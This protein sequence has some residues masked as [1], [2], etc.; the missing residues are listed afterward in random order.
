MGLVEEIE[1]VE[2]PE[3]EKVRQEELGQEVSAPEKGGKEWVKARKT[4]R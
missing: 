3:Q 4:G 2:E 1:V